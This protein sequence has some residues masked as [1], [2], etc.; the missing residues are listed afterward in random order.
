MLHPLQRA[1]YPARDL[2]GRI[3]RV[4]LSGLR[5]GR[6]PGR[7]DV[8][9]WRERVRGPRAACSSRNGGGCGRCEQ[10][11]DR[12][13]ARAVC[14]PQ[15]GPWGLVVG[16]WRPVELVDARVELWL[17]QGGGVVNDADPNGCGTRCRC[18]PRGRHLALARWVCSG[19]GARP[20]PARLAARVALALAGFAG[21]AVAVGARACAAREPTA[22]AG[23]AGLPAAVR[24]C[25]RGGREAWC[26]ARMVRR[27]RGIRGA[28]NPRGHPLQARQRTALRGGGLGIHRLACGG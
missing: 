25:A 28:R 27:W 20:F 4:G 19:R 7:G 9:R 22:W 21:A 26:A 24:L 8:L 10:P 12:V 11:W 2:A 23:P 5:R 17:Q 3:Q 14:G 6:V 1:V 13:S 16:Q 18:V 15:A